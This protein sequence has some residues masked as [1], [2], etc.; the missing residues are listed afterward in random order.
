MFMYFGQDAAQAFSEMVHRR[1]PDFNKLFAR[2][3]QPDVS[4]MIGMQHQ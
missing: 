3:S 1:N 4:L 2:N